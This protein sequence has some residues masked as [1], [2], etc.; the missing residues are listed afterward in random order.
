MARPTEIRPQPL[1][2]EAPYFRVGGG[3][4]FLRGREKKGEG[5]RKRSWSKLDRGVFL[6]AT[7][8]KDAT[9][10][11]ST[12]TRGKKKKKKERK[13]F[14]T[15]TESASSTKNTAVPDSP[16]GRSYFWKSKEKW[17]GGEGGG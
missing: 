2:K 3:E 14:P 11:G 13:I 6:A 10:G 17:K 4:E 8:R 15:T 16:G 1:E 9:S 5:K 7:R 12:R